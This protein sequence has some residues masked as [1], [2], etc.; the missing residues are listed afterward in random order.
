MAHS[1]TAV[2]MLCFGI[3]LVISRWNSTAEPAS[4]E[5]SLPTYNHSN[6]PHIIHQSYKTTELPP[7]W[8]TAPSMWRATHPDYAYQFWTDIDNRE[9]IR[10]R[11]PWFLETYDG[12]PWPIQRADAARYFAVLTYGGVYVDL[13]HLPLRSITP[14]L[15][16]VNLPGQ[17]ML[18]AETSNVGLTNAFFAATPSSPTLH[19]FVHTLAAHQRPLLGSLFPHF[20]VMMSTGPTYFWKALAKDDA[21]I[22]R[23][24]ATDWGRC[25]LC[26]QACKP[27]PR[28]FFH[29]V[30]GGSWHRS[31]TSFFNWVF[32]HRE[33]AI[34]IW[35]WATVEAKGRWDKSKLGTG[36]PILR[37]SS[38]RI[39]MFARGTW[40]N[41]CVA[42]VLLA[43]H[44]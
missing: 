37:A 14:L 8:A 41:F 16:K 36:V 44:W 3:V 21:D 30:D 24:R 19:R 20:A 6:I 32:C 4:T 29:H 10:T 39:R 31:D 38:I 11:Y 2:L 33:F 22:V 25:S 12:Y 17:D 35:M 23:I 1:L 43:V 26:R 28:A 7:Q 40:G 5:D 42:C 34:W 13:D 27:G 15:D 9:L 18:V